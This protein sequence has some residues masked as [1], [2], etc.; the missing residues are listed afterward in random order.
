MTEAVD[1]EALAPGSTVVRAAG[2]DLAV[3]PLKLRQIGPVA[4]LLRQVIAD[5]MFQAGADSEIGSD[6]LLALFTDHDEDII[7]ALAIM[8]DVDRAWVAELNLDDALQ[9]LLVCIQVNRDFFT[10]RLGG[11]SLA[12]VQAPGAGPTP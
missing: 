10:Q 2:R 11:L 8:A 7:S 6:Q 3:S 1:W 12:G 9:L 5:P 4:R